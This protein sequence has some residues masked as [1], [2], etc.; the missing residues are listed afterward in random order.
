MEC[1]PDAT[2]ARIDPGLVTPEAGIVTSVGATAA[3][4]RAV[5]LA[6]REGPAAKS[7]LD[8]VVAHGD[9][10]AGFTWPCDTFQLIWS[11]DAY[12]KAGV[13]PTDP[14][15]VASIENLHGRWR[16]QP[17]GLG[18]SPYFP[19]RDGDDIAMAFSVLRQAGYEV[20]DAPLLACW[21]GRLLESYPGERVHG[22][23]VNLSAL[24]ALRDTAPRRPEHDDMAHSI[25]SWLR[26]QMASEG[27]LIDPWHFSPAYVLGRGIDPLLHHDPTLAR[28]WAERLFH[29][30]RADGG[31]GYGEACTE[32]ETALAVLGLLGARRAGMP[33]TEGPLRQA[34]R[35]LD[36]HRTAIKARPRLWL[37]KGLYLAVNVAEAVSDAARVGLRLAGLDD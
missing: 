20:S 3:Y 25:L 8:T 28:E 7:Y 24:S 14:L 18:H 2:L 11:I 29:S 36:A 30:Q 10:G 31:W 16:N 23:S 4:L 21:N 5:R 27:P 32:E 33:Q 13:R 17:E 19:V 37:A 34:S 15:L 22:L 12:L 6:G 26:E 35:Y 1:L 9:G